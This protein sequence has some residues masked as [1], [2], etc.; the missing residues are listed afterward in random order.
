MGSTP[1]DPEH[2]G[3]RPVWWWG[4]TGVTLRFGSPVATTNRGT[5]GRQL[6]IVI[7]ITPH[8][9]VRGAAAVTS[10]V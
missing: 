5:D 6:R 2:G 8:E 9:R 4:V 10:R 7:G 3:G 1:T